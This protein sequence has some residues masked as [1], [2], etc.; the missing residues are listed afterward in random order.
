M[1][2]FMEEK[3]IEKE[4]ESVVLSVEEERIV[5]AYTLKNESEEELFGEMLTPT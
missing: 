4:K 3:R 1:K 5:K 2:R